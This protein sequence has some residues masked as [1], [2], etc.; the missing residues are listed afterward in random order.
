MRN[1]DNV[2]LIAICI[3]AALG[4]VAFALVVKQFW[5]EAPPDLGPVVVCPAEILTFNEAFRKSSPRTLD[6]MPQISAPCLCHFFGTPESI[7]PD[8]LAMMNQKCAAST[9]Q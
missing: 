7:D 6:G 2:R 8:A 3:A 4:F 9:D 1:Q 5:K